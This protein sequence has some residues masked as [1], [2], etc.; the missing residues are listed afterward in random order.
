MAQL[1]DDPGS[2]GS[3]S[4]PVRF[5]PWHTIIA[6][7]WDKKPEEPPPPPPPPS[8]QPYCGSY[9]YGE[10]VQSVSPDRISAVPYGPILKAPFVGTFS[11]RL[12]VGPG[13]RD[14][15]LSHV[16]TDLS[17]L[18]DNGA[19]IITADPFGNIAT[20]ILLEYTSLSFTNFQLLGELINAD[21]SPDNNGWTVPMAQGGFPPNVVTGYNIR[22][23]WNIVSGTVDDRDQV[24]LGMTHPFKVGTLPAPSVPFAILGSRTGGSASYFYDFKY[25]DFARRGIGI[26]TEANQFDPAVGGPA[27]LW[28]M[29]KR[30]F[31]TEWF[32]SSE[33]MWNI[34]SQIGD[35]Y[36]WQ[37][38]ATCAPEPPFIFS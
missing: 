24:G 8:G 7:Q 31:E 32:A 17:H 19:P 12:P 22:M 26:F 33:F 14:G 27:V 34:L 18:D 15:H 5:D 35:N 38:T 11:T 10:I 3:P 23:D 36:T 29:S 16:N 28:W 6:V 21:G 9:G 30:W 4:K 13:G 1:P 37:I 2:Y 20:S 25:L